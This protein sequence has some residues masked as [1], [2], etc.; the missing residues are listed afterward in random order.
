MRTAYER[1][2]ERER[3][4]VCRVLNAHPMSAPP[5]RMSP[6]KRW[7]VE[8][9]LRR[10]RIRQKV[11]A[12]LHQNGTATASQ[13]A[14]KTDADLSHVLG[15]LRGSA[16]RYSCERSLLHLDLVEIVG[17]SAPAYYR[18][19]PLALS[20]LQEHPTPEPEVIA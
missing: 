7:A 20:I 6:G 5:S 17:G 19:T 9:A 11:L 2:R 4:F 1:E 3:A 10:S 15:A 16:T 12:H 14:R 18:L 8:H 13:I